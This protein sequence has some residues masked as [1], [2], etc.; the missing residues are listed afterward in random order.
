[1]TMYCAFIVLTQCTLTSKIRH[2]VF[3][4]GG[5]SVGYLMSNMFSD[6]LHNYY[7]KSSTFLKQSARYHEH[8]F[9]CKA[10]DISV[11]F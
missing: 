9:S 7:L 5:N 8:T 1:M 11:L 4:S 2:G 10:P 6:F 3:F